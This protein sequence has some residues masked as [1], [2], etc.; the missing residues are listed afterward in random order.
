MGQHTVYTRGH[1][2]QHLQG[3]E[4]RQQLG[5]AE[6]IGRNHEADLIMAIG[7]LATVP[8]H[9][10]KAIDGDQLGRVS[11]DVE[12]ADPGGKAG[13]NHEPTIS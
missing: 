2:L 11:R 13:E 5:A 1:C 12:R 6:E 3:T 10:L 8:E 7:K 9:Q 4:A